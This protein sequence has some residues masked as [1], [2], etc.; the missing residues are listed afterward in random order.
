VTLARRVARCLLPALL[1]VAAPALAGNA[2]IV[3]DAATGAVLRA[4]DATRLWRPASLTKLMTLYVIFQDVAAGHF[5]LDDPLTV[6]TYAASMPPSSIGLAPGEKITVRQAVLATITRSANDA[7]VAL[8]ERDAGDEAAFAQRMTRAARRLGMTGSNFHNATGLPDPE[9]TTTARDMAVL[10]LALIR[11]YPQ[12]YAFFAARGVTFRGGYLPTI[13]AILALYQGADGLKTGFT[14]GSGY[15][16]VASAVR[17]GRRVVGVL[18]GG[19]TSDQRYRETT[20]LL[21]AGFAHE[22][23]EDPLTLDQMTQLLPGDPPQQLSAQECAPGWAL[24]ANAQVAGRLP[25]WGISFGGF[26]RAQPTRAL[27]ERTLN[28]LPANLRRGRAAV[29]ARP[30]Q[31]LTSYRAVVVGLSREEAAGACHLLWGSGS[32][33]IALPP[34]VLNNPRAAWR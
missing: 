21:D 23:D 13:N 17:G 14:C 5:G 20:D 7:A 3:V 11:D 19:L 2:S 30:Y 32:Y 31:G 33:C 24:S 10:A 18:L 9:Q 12:F 34:V 27:L 4:D 28:R 15:N 22:V 8:A 1:L 25:G 29:V 6:S 16:L 26:P